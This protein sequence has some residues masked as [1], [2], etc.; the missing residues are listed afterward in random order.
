MTTPTN[1]EERRAAA[2]RLGGDI[3]PVDVYLPWAVLDTSDI[4]PEIRES[5]PEELAA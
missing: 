2:E 3:V 4:D 1:P 5:T